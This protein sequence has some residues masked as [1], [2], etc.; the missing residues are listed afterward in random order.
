[1]NN[2]KNIFSRIF[3]HKKRIALVLAAAIIIPY[4]SQ[5]FLKWQEREIYSNQQETAREAASAEDENSAADRFS[6]FVNQ[7][8]Y[9]SALGEVELLLSLNPSNPEYYLK[10]AGLYVLLERSGEALVDLDT[11]LTMMPD[12]YDALQ[13]RSQIYEESCRYAEAAADY[14]RM[15][16]L[17]PEEK[18]V[19][20]YEAD[21]Y[22]QM[23]DYKAAID[24]YD[25]AESALPAYANAIAY[26]RG[27]C[28]Y[29]LEDYQSALSDLL[30]Y[31]STTPEDGELNFLI[32][33]CYMN[34]GKEAAAENYLLTA[35]NGSSYL[36]ETN[37]YL[38]AI[39]MD[40]EEYNTAIPYF[41]TAIDKQCFTDFS[42]YNR[43]ICYLHT[44]QLEQARDDFQYVA[45]NSADSSLVSD[46]EALLNQLSVS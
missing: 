46:S 31:Y 23:G 9:E 27:V 10:R 19:L 20:M 18:D 13:L 1:M 4:F 35:L 6:E 44:E 36:A 42:T 24:A 25:K 5:L 22:Q 38:G 17:N 33:S 26:A 40:K 14:K 30:R 7:G 32:G 34:L 12:L 2:Q 39:Y 28:F 3:A 16:E 43:G 21:C 11:A 45:E 8:D 29:S 37:F 15:Y 41:T